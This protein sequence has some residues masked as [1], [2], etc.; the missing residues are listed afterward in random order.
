M[1]FKSCLIYL[2]I[3]VL[4]LS[5]GL[6]VGYFSYPYIYEFIYELNDA[7][8]VEMYLNKPAPDF[9]MMTFDG[10][11]WKPSDENGKVIMLDFWATWCAP[12]IAS[13]PEIKEIYEKYSDREDFVIVGIC[14][15]EAV[16][17]QKAEN[18]IKEKEIKWLQL[19]DPAKGWDVPL[20]TEL[21]I[22]SI[23]TVVLIDQEGIIRTLNIN[24]KDKIINMIDE[25]LL[26]KIEND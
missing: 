2:I 10:G 12:C 18:T 15:D 20:A 14:L 22:S 13:I 11:T 5:I 1:G 9:E 26:Q 17:R 24:G 21:K 23:P 7:R 6:T 16:G 19:H 4:F 8:A 25:L 3:A